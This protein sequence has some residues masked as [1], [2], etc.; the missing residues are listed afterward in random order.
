MLWLPPNV[1]F[2]GSQST[3][4]GGVSPS[5]GMDCHICCWLAHHM[6][7]VLMTPLGRLVEPEVNKN[8]TMVSGPMAFIA[9][10]TSAVSGVS[11]K[12]PNS[13]CFLSTNRP[14]A[15]TTS[16]SAGT[17]ASMAAPYLSASV[18]NTKPGVKV[19][20]MWRSLS[21]SLLTVEYAGDT[22]QWGMP[23]SRQPSATMACSKLFSLR[24]TTGRSA[25][26][27]RANKAWPMRLAPAK[28][29]P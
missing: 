10:S 11:N 3:S 5:T 15:N 23:T 20:R 27:F 2:H 8:L 16:V 28:A 22:G 9:A 4:T 18:A 7:C 12:A 14:F 19:C 13:V 1:W 21:K 24:M 26:K 29:R 25:L 6:P 17:V